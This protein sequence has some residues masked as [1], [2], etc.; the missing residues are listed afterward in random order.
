MYL[1]W[2]IV[3]RRIFV[4]PVSARAE[5]PRPVRPMLVRMVFVVRRSDGRLVAHLATSGD[6]CLLGEFLQRVLRVAVDRQWTVQVQSG[7]G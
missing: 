1:V 7:R 3:G 6:A 4:V 5:L 2:S